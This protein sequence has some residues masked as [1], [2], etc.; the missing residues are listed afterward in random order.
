MSDAEEIP[1]PREEPIFIVGSSGRQPVPAIC[2]LEMTGAEVSGYWHKWNALLADFLRTSPSRPLPHPSRLV[3]GEYGGRLRAANPKAARALGQMY[4]R[5]LT[6]ALGEFPKLLVAHMPKRRARQE[7]RAVLDWL[8][9]R[10]A[11]RPSGL[12]LIHTSRGIAWYRL[13]ANGPDLEP[14]PPDSEAL[15]ALP[16]SAAEIELLLTPAK[17]GSY[18]AYQD[19]CYPHMNCRPTWLPSDL[20]WASERI[21]GESFT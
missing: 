1:V 21:S 16:R 13:T 17:L 3:K 7:E 14:L 5:Q 15:K 4:A 8:C 11:G 10:L 20:P 18:A 12:A 9:T 19:R 6:K 2:V